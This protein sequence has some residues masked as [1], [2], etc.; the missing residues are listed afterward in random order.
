MKILQMLMMV[1]V[2]TSLLLRPPAVQA[3]EVALPANYQF[4]ETYTFASA[5]LPDGFLIDADAPQWYLNEGFMGY[6]R[7]QNNGT[8]D[9]YLLPAYLLGDME[10]VDGQAIGSGLWAQAVKIGRNESL[11]LYGEGDIALYATNFKPR[12]FSNPEGSAETLTSVPADQSGQFNIVYNQKLVIIPFTQ[13]LTLNP[14]YKPEGTFHRYTVAERAELAPYIVHAISLDTVG[15]DNTS[16]DFRVVKWLKGNGPVDITIDG[17]GA[18]SCDYQMDSDGERIFFVAG[19]IERGEMTLQDFQP[20]MFD[21]IVGVEN[22]AEISRVV[23]QEPIV[24]DSAESTPIADVTDTSQSTSAN[25]SAPTSG[26]PTT[27]FIVL[28]ILVTLTIG[29]AYLNMKWGKR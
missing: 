8:A 15:Y 10:L 13:S 20:G 17:F 24:L 22:A 25:T 2:V 3:C 14:D 23:G 4:S 11:E 16:G 12:N 7:L 27:I 26:L 6:L 5:S 19:D 1:V 9:L 18:T 21:A 29:L 28:T